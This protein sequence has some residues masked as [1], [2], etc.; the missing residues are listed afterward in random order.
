[1]TNDLSKQAMPA[2]EK[3]MKATPDQLYEQLGIRQIAI[4]LDPSKSEDFDPHVTYDFV[5]MMG[6]KEFVF[7]FGKQLF[8]RW[9]SEAYK[10]SCG[11]SDS[12][13]SDRKKLMEAL[14]LGEASLGAAVAAV[15]V[16]H[17]VLAPVTATIVGVL[18]V[19]LFFRP[20]YEE[21]CKAWTKSVEKASLS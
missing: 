5:M 8:K 19:K 6:P 18:L 9:Q 10:L 17:C 14:G 7:N 16:A 1:M 4:D 13:A 20:T 21:F 15:L 12:N 2:V 3:W 11:P